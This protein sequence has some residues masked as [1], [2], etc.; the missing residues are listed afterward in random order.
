MILNNELEL[1]VPAGF[2]E[3]DAAERAKLT[4]AGGEPGLCI[5][6][7]E[8]HIM[9][10]AGWRALGTFAAMLVDVKGAAKNAEKQLGRLMQSYG[11]RKLETS[12]KDLGGK[13][14]G[15]YKYTYDV[16]DIGMLGESLYV[17]NGK[18]LYGFN[19]YCRRALE[20]ESM[21]VWEKLLRSVRWL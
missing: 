21:P 19:F 13:A 17:K 8:R 3:M 18:T 9:V 11:Y 20:K 12:A 14:A 2:H 1:T 16:G 4:F 7:P 5:S 10:T 6:D 15:G